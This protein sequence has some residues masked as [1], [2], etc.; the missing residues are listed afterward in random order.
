MDFID[1]VREIST[2]RKFI[3]LGVFSLI[4]GCA[5]PAGQWKESDFLSREIILNIPVSKALN[6]FQMGM[7]YC[8]E[9]SGPQFGVTRHGVE[10]C[11]PIQ[12]DGSVLCD[13]HFGA[14][15][16]G[17]DLVLGRLILRPQDNG[18]IA[19]ISVRNSM[20][21][22]SHKKKSLQAWEMFLNGL[23]QEVCPEN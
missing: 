18:S 14:G 7:R 5:T 13:I 16:R 21:R 9:S 12:E 4:V 22:H 11:M 10:T 1:K 19:I 15:S 17:T 2:V 6:Q 8:G 20:L 23:A 3:F